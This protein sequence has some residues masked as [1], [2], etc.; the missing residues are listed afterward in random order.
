MDRDQHRRFRGIRYA[1]AAAAVLLWEIMCSPASAADSIE[2]KLA[3]FM[4]PL[5]VQHQESFMPFA[6]NVEKLTQGRVRIKVYAGGPD[7]SRSHETAELAVSCQ[8]PPEL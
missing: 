8:A 6:Q 1:S 2:L 3:H 4:S 5:H 7:G